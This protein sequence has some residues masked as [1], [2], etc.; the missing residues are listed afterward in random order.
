M[1]TSIHDMCACVLNSVLTE[2]HKTLT[3]SVP[4]EIKQSKES[5]PYCHHH[6]YDNRRL[7]FSQFSVLGV[8]DIIRDFPFPPYQ[9]ISEEIRRMS[10]QRSA[11]DDSQSDDPDHSSRWDDECCVS[12]WDVETDHEGRPISCVGLVLQREGEKERGEAVWRRGR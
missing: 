4:E 7:P 12:M 9:A 6:S 1:Y 11:D 8:D 10:H 3:H 5:D 2:L